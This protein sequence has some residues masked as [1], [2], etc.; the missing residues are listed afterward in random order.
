M[1]ARLSD[2]LVETARRAA[3][4][5]MRHRWKVWFW[6]DSIGLE[7]LLEASAI[8]GDAQYAGYVHGLMKGWLARREHRSKFDYT[9]A[10]V[11]LLRVYEQTGDDSLLEAAYEHANYLAAFRRTSA[12]VRAEDA[13]SRVAAGAA[14]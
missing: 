9:A 1:S 2:S 3:G 12:F 7:G 11:A 14:G 13:A 10:G 4:W 6:A 8:T 5:L